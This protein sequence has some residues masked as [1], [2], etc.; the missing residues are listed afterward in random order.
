[1]RRVAERLIRKHEYSFEI[2]HSPE[3]FDNFYYNMY[4][5][6]MNS[7]HGDLADPTPYQEAYH[8]FEQ[9]WLHK[10]IRQGEFVGGAIVYTSSETLYVKLMG[11]K[12]ADEQLRREGVYYAV[13][14]PLL[15]EANK[16]NFA[17]AN[18]GKSAPFPKL[19]FF[20]YKRRWGMSIKAVP[21]NDF[22]LWIYFHRVTPAVTRF[23]T[24][25]P[26]ICLQENGDFCGLLTVDSLAGL[27]EVNLEKQRHLYLVPG[28]KDWRVCTMQ[29]LVT[30]PSPN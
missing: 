15:V 28:V 7:T 17:F 10:I 21:H 18:F 24:D 20:Q 9:G 29:N 11:L 2:S 4:L 8:Y 27:D 23:I 3:D 26:L 12:N 14:Y 16:N 30:S 5:P 1:M 6:S 13:Y 22:Q 25:N 19:S